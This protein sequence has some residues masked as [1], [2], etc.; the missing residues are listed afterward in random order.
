[1]SEKLDMMARQ[2]ARLSKLVSELLD[3]SRITTGRLALELETWDIGSL[4]REAASR[5]ADDFAK[6]GAR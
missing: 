2:A 5:L 3:V 1:M 6:S 4:V